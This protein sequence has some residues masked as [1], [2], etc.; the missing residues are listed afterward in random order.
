[1]SVVIIAEQYDKVE[2]GEEANECIVH[3]RNDI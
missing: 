2:L 1:M 3:D